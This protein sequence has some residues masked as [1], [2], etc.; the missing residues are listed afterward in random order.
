[1]K[2]T[3]KCK[4]VTSGRLTG[5]VKVQPARRRV[6]PNPGPAACPE[7]AYSL[8][9]TDSEDQV[10]SLHKG[11]DQCAALLSGILQAEKAVLPSLPRAVKGRAAK[12]RPSAS[13]GKKTAKKLPSK[14]V[15]RGPGSTTPTTTHQ[16]AVPSARSEVKF[17]PPQKQPRTLLQSH[18]PPSHNQTLQHLSPTTPPPQPQMSNPPPQPQTSAPPPQTSIPPPYST[19]HSGWPP[20]PQT[21]CQAAS[22]A[23]HAHCKAECDS[24]EEEFVPVRDI[25]TQS[26]AADTHTA[27]RHTHTHIDTCIMK[28]S[29]MQLEPGQV[30]KVPQD[31]H[32][33]EDCS[34]ETEV[35]TVQYLL[36]EL[37]ALIAG[38]GSVAER[39][40]SHLEQTLS[41]PLMNVGR[42]NIQTEPDLSSI[43]SQNT[44]L[45]RHVSILNQQLQERE[46]AEKQQDISDKLCNSEVLTLQ[47]ELTT[48]QSRLRELEDALTELRTALQDT[49]S[50]LRDREAENALIKT[51]LKATRSRLLDS[52]QEKS[53]LASLAQ[54]RLEEIGNLNRILQRRDSSDCTAV[55]DSSVSLLTKQHFNQ[56]QHRQEPAEPPTDRI[57]QY[58][59]SLGQLEPTHTEHVYVVAERE[60]NTLEQ[61]KLTSVQ[62]RDTFRSQRGDKPSETSARHQNSHLDQSHCLDEVQ[63]CGQRLEKEHRQLL[64][65]TLC[66]HDMESVWSDWSTRSGLIFDT[67][68]EAAFRDGLAALDASI[69]NLQKTIQLDLGK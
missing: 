35:K 52:E 46:K 19:P 23:P 9:S 65:S 21:D 47:E 63:S 6:T 31:T 15:Q 44:Q 37:K 4:V 14:T 32:S 11:L 1:M 60:G 62:L 16:S 20:L 22:E 53:E 30:N 48:T 26:T 50:Q 45:R 13:L 17:H 12:S 54:Q 34:A 29:N 58:L 43:H 57:T 56:H 8:Y 25:N 7:P 27:V 40:L 61:K 51:D 64:N 5:G 69:A 67:R 38:Q 24:E 36:G 55:V 18:L 42:S 41:S 33:V 49:Q 28:M 3:A 2:G 10:I 68:D 66:Q 39:L 59:M